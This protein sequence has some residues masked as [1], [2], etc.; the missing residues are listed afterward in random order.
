MQVKIIPD[1]DRDPSK[2]LIDLA[3]TFSVAAATVDYI[4]I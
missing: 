1:P 3:Y 2:A 4:D